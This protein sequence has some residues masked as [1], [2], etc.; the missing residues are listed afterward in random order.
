VLAWYDVLYDFIDKF[1]PTMWGWLS[2]PF[3]P[4]HYRGQYDQLPVKYKK[5][6]RNVDIAVLLVLGILFVI[7][8]VF[9]RR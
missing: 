5:L 7:P 8:F 2:M 6:I 1:G 9:P 4:P 3:K